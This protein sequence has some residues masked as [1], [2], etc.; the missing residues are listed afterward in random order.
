MMYLYMC[1]YVVNN[2]IYYKKT[3][4]RLAVFVFYNIYYIAF[5]LMYDFKYTS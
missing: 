2:K 5:N 4:K 3:K 1:I